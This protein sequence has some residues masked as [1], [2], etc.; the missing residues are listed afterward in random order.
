MPRG[1]HGLPREEVERV[2]R[3]RLIEAMVLVAAE[4]SYE[5]ITIADVTAAAGVSRKT[6]Y[7]AFSNKEECFHAAYAAVVGILVA[8][9][10]ACVR[11]AAWTLGAACARQRCRDRRD[12]GVGA[13]DRA[14]R[15][16]R[17]DHG[18]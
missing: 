14:D 3:Q 2:Q 18:E 5:A 15:D 13:P 17:A 9:A 7:E 4:K 16:A 8:R 1:R 11:P 12:G 10:G 6:Y